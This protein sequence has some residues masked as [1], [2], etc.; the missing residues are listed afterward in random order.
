MRWT[1]S[2]FPSP[3]QFQLNVTKVDAEDPRE[4]PT[5]DVCLLP[6]LYCLMALHLTFRFALVVAV[7]VT[8]AL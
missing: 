4:N 6:N 5:E 1:V 3:K 8:L 7:L 2:V